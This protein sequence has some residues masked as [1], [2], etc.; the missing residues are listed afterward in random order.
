MIDKAF[1]IDDTPRSAL[2]L[3]L[4]CE[5]CSKSTLTPVWATLWRAKKSR[6]FCSAEH[7]RV[8]E[9]AY[10]KNEW[11]ESYPAGGCQD[12]QKCGKP[13]CRACYGARRFRGEE[14]H[15]PHFHAHNARFE[16]GKLWVMTKK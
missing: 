3:A 13:T 2:S 1:Q 6:A 14:V 16:R 9:T 12:G 5:W 8:Y 7:A 11:A 15:N 4:E 10:F